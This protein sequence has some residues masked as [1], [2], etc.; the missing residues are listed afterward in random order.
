MNATATFK[1]SIT[2]HLQHR[3]GEVPTRI[4]DVTAV[5]KE[6]GIRKPLGCTTSRDEAKA[7]CAA[8]KADAVLKMLNG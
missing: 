2:S 3:F 6:T 1:Y 4:Y 8:H 7:L 5:C